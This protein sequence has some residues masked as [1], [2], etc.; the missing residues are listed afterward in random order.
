VIY[1]S[2]LRET[3]K[4]LSTDVVKVNSGHL[5][6]SGAKESLQAGLPL[7]AKLERHP[8]QRPYPGIIPKPYSFWASDRYITRTTLAIQNKPV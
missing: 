8:S 6:N 5:S 4:I 3:I 7:F 1:A 2:A